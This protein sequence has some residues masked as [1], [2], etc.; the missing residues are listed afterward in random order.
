MISG[1]A[2]WPGARLEQVV[3]TAADFQPGVLYDRIVDHSVRPDGAGPPSAML[4][5]PQ[6]CSDALT[7]AIAKTAE[8]GPGT[9]ATYGVSCDGS[10][11]QFTVLTSRLDLDLLAAEA[12]RCENYQVY[13][14]P[15]SEGIPITTVRLPSPREGTLVYKQSSTLNG[16][17]QSTHA[18]FASV[19]SMSVFGIAVSLDDSSIGVKASL[20]QTFLNIVVRQADR[21]KSV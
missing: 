19:G 20:P 2:T 10:R 16:F 6:G 14:D 17:T 21:L 5:K 4:S 13:F 18:G 12:T 15:S 11:M 1:T 7:A 8:R 3:L 9:A